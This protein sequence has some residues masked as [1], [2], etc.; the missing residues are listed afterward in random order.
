MTVGLNEI[1]S[2]EIDKQ[3]QKALTT[4]DQQIE[5]DPFADK[6]TVPVEVAWV[7]K[8]SLASRGCGPKPECIEK[9]QKSGLEDSLKLDTDGNIVE[10]RNNFDAKAV[11]D[12]FKQH[13]LIKDIL[14]SLRSEYYLSK[15][16]LGTVQ[17]VDTPDIN[18][19][20]TI[21]PKDQPAL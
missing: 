1:V 15:L 20:L 13:P 12:A 21:S 19:Q 18:L 11:L 6:W 8:D 9:F 3:K 7:P 4:L 17:G 5:R 10:S 16:S 14:A 2:K